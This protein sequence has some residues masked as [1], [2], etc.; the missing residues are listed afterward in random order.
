MLGAFMNVRINA[1]SYEDKAW[2]ESTLQKG[3]EIENKALALEAEILKTV[4][5]KLGN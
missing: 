5:E 4:N 1:G 2:V 3:R